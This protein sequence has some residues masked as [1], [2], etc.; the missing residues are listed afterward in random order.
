MQLPRCAAGHNK[1][2][3]ERNS[4]MWCQD[5]QR[6]PRKISTSNNMLGLFLLCLRYCR[7][8][9]VNFFLLSISVLD[10]NNLLIG[11]YCYRG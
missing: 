4:D 8:V 9:E 1:F 10:L 7:C 11:D 6:S 2:L 3:K 5:V